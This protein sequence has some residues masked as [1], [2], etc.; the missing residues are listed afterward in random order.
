M[1]PAMQL[2]YA[3]FRPLRAAGGAYDGPAGYAARPGAGG[4][5]VLNVRAHCANEAGNILFAPPYSTAVDNR[6]VISVS[7]QIDD[8][9][10]T[11][12]AMGDLVIAGMRQCLNQGRGFAI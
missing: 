9:T 3:V 5:F 8:R 7:E 1:Q 2:Q 11:I 12:R 6:A 10:D 4:G